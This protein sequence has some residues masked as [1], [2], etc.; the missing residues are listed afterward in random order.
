MPRKKMDLVVIGFIACLA[1]RSSLAMASFAALAFCKLLQPRTGQT[2]YYDRCARKKEKIKREKVCYLQNKTKQ[3]HIALCRTN[4]LRVFPVSSAVVRSGV[5]PSSR[6]YV[7]IL[8][9]RRSPPC[10]RLRERPEPSP[11]PRWPANPA[12]SRR[13]RPLFAPCPD[14]TPRPGKY[15]RSAV[16]SIPQ[17][18]DQTWRSS[19][20]SFSRL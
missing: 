2:L 6:R 17:A 19:L 5:E 14:G 15:I 11:R 13:R 12:E 9:R 16:R 20:F 4:T 10:P 8:Q 7:R 1:T 18:A 3:N